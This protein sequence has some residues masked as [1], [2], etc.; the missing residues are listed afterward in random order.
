MFFYITSAVINIL[1]I[2]KINVYEKN[3]S[4]IYHFS[5]TTKSLLENFPLSL[6]KKADKQL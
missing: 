1:H 2:S 3:K 6:V 5:I 4:P